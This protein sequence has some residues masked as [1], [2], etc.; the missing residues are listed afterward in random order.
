MFY[1]VDDMIWKFIYWY[2]ILFKLSIL[3]ALHENNFY[4]AKLN[5]LDL[6]G[7]KL[8]FIASKICYI[9]V[10][11]LSSPTIIIWIYDLISFQASSGAITGACQLAMYCS[12]ELVFFPA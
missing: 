10:P 5:V 8:Y 1:H 12:E 4:N 9:S 11:L 7:Y 6:L 2:D 3:F